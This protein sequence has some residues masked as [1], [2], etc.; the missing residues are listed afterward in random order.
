[1]QY[2]AHD[3]WHELRAALTVGADGRFSRI[4]KLAGFEPVKTSPP[5]DVLWFR[6]P[7]EADDPQ[8]SGFVVGPGHFLV[9]LD[10]GDEWQFGYIITKGGYQQIKAAGLAQFRQ[11]VGKLV[12]EFAERMASITEWKQIAVLSVESSHVERWYKPGLLLIGDAAH[13]MTPVGGV[14]INYAIQDAV[15]TANILTPGLTVGKVRT[16]DLARVQRRRERPARQIQAF[17][18]R[19]QDLFLARVLS[20]DKPL[21]LPLLA[22]LFMKLPV[23][24]NR[25]AKLIGFGPRP[26][27]V[28]NP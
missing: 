16:E 20:T 6:L 4:R 21:A 13:V 2:R 9:R 14:G 5:M 12:P 23:L 11:D 28:K 26:E 8:E 27:R 15:A 17:Q 19:A 22:R 7:H 25:Q 1:V 24:R 18:N 3:G 10:R